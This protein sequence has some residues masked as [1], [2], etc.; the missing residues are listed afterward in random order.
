MKF[1][2]GLKIGKSPEDSKSSEGN[3]PR[4]PAHDIFYDRHFERDGNVSGNRGGGYRGKL[5]G[6]RKIAFTHF[7]NTSLVKSQYQSGLEFTMLCQ[8]SAMT[9]VVPKIL[10]KLTVKLRRCRCS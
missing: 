4:M 6:K 2:S 5:K 9:S 1:V 8:D 3:N 7:L 10:S